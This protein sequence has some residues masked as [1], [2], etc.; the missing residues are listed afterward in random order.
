[1]RVDGNEL[2][3]IIADLIGDSEKTLKAYIAEVEK[4]PGPAGQDADPKAVA[5][6]L[7]AD[8][9]FI[10]ST[11]GAD[12]LSIK[13]VEIEPDKSAFHLIFE[14]GTDVKIEL[15]QGEKGN[16][17]NPGAP[18]RNADPN[19]VAALLKND[20]DF[21][22]RIKG[23][24]GAPGL[25]IKAVEIEPDNSAFHL[26]FEDDTDVK[27][28]L[29]RG[30]KGEPGKDADPAAVAALLVDQLKSDLTFKEELKGKPGVS[31]QNVT[32]KDYEILVCLDNGDEY[33]FALPKGEN[34]KD[35]DPN[36]VANCLCKNA[37]FLKLV[38]GPKG[39]Q[40]EP[41][42]QGEPGSTGVPGA[43]I[44]SKLFI[45]GEIYR[46]DD[47][48][49]AHIGQFFQALKDTSQT[50]GDSDH[51]QRLGECG[52][53]FLGPK[54]KDES[55]LKS[56][57]WFIDGGSLF[58]HF[59]GETRMIIKRPKDADNLQVAKH[60]AKNKQFIET[61]AG[62]C[63]KNADFFK[64]LSSQMENSVFT[65]HTVK[66]DHFINALA[67][68]CVKQEHFYK[69]F[70][71]EFPELVNSVDV[72]GHSIY[73]TL[74]NEQLVEIDL[75][76]F[77]FDL[78]SEIVESIKKN[79]LESSA[80]PDIESIPVKFYRGRWDQSK[81]YQQGDI[82]KSESTVW[83]AKTDPT[84][85][86]LG[87][88]EQW[89]KL[90]S[91]PKTILAKPPKALAGF[92][93]SYATQQPVAVDT[94]IGVSFG[95]GISN[96]YL[97]IDANGLLTFNQSGI[98]EFVGYFALDRTTNPGI[99][100]SFFQLL[101]NGVPAVNPVGIDLNTA[102]VTIPFQFTL[103]D[104]NVSAGDQLQIMFYND[105]AGNNDARLSSKISSVY[106]Q[107]VSA[108]LRVYIVN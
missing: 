73:L 38:Q 56:G 82:V 80:P 108:S 106:G 78:A 37:D 98:Y 65:K 89:E 91:S 99:S 92:S 13:A 64:S 66:S 43:G 96:N 61:V 18:G 101:K 69:Q 51:W 19:E 107:S 95:A 81:Q 31:I 75:K 76:A 21:C 26:I 87:D 3:D 22:G 32:S 10:A 12:G 40:G 84:A 93:F 42:P 14:D 2:L 4:Q 11:K 6:L 7:K 104:V 48:V 62:D 94:P 70:M 50:P 97:D 9:D 72:K 15:P 83:L 102:S 86:N 25:G 53:R 58:M 39:E 44:T 49:Q 8:S 74:F 63:I 67:E 30:E 45:D 90:F 55:T 20:G 88:P 57:D 68:Q 60:T 54:P 77:A 46:K 33:S 29:A 79:L 36:Q 59:K 52:F 16:D 27:I 105:S 41:G 1:M 5:D 28:E 47:I 85:G 23:K 100:R 71:T 17:G 35:A 103:T 34:G 24:D